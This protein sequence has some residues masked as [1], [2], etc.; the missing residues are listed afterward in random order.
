MYGDTLLNLPWLLNVLHYI[1]VAFANAIQGIFMITGWK[2][3]KA[4]LCFVE[5]GKVFA[6]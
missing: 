4:F 1:F 3:Y 6:L 2:M 5:F